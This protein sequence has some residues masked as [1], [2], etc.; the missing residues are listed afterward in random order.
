[1][2][3]HGVGPHDYINISFSVTDIGHIAAG[4][5]FSITLPYL[6]LELHK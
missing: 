3:N 2:T 6:A 1:M 5:L 4:I